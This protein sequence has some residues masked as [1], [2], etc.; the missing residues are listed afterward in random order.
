M[1]R[2]DSKPLD[3]RFTPSREQKVRQPGLLVLV[4]KLFR[5]IPYFLKPIATT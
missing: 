3:W 4:A 2:G 5:A 1:R